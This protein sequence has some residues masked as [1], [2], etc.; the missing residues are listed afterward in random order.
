MKK[1]LSIVLTVIIAISI[2]CSKKSPTAAQIVYALSD[3]VGTWAG[4]AENSSNALNLTLSVDNTGKVSGSGVSSTWSVDESGKV[5]GGGSF[6]FVSGS[7]YTVAAA[8]W[9][10]V[11]NQG[12][13]TLTGKFNVAYPSL[14]DMDVNLVKE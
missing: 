8:G 13:T 11:L 12:K 7:S 1:L 6:S 3:I 5:T 14:H 10:M 9:H 4:T 2:S